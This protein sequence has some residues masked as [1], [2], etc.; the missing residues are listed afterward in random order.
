[1]AHPDDEILGCGG[2][3]SKMTQNGE[4]A[5]SFILGEGIT[6]RYKQREEADKKEIE[7]L[8]ERTIKAAELVGISRTFWQDLP[9]N[10][11]DT[12]PLLKI[13]KSIESMIQKIQPD[14]IFTHHCGDLNIDHTIVARAVLTATRPI[15]YSPVKD[16]Y[17]CEIPSSTDW[18]FQNLEPIWRPNVFFD[19]SQTLETKLLA[20]KEYE[21]EMRPQ[22]HP[23]SY[24]NVSGIAQRWGSLIGTHAAEAFQLIRSIR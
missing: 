19:I 17:A 22:P 15:K 20:L 16:I 8:H 9:D 23:R 12:V 4:E 2:I 6:S 13:V 14:I 10:M 18:S 5:Y 3:I 11:F 21:P 24:Q 7:L 1:M